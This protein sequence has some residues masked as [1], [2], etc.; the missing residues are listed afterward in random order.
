M[1]LKAGGV[2]QA[3]EQLHSNPEALSSS[4]ITTKIKYVLKST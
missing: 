1:F 4:P 3:V 2:V